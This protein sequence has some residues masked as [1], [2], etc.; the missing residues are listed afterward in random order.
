MNQHITEIAPYTLKTNRLRW[1]KPLS[2]HSGTNSRSA[3]AHYRVLEVARQQRA[4]DAVSGEYPAVVA[5]D[6]LVTEEIGGGCGE[7]REIAAEIEV[8]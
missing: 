3:I 5:A 2:G 4:G 6:V 7:Q 8:D 1:L